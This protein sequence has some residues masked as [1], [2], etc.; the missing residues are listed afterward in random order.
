LA[1]FGRQLNALGADEGT[2]PSCCPGWDVRAMASHVLGMT[3]M[4]SSYP[5]MARQ[6]LSAAKAIKGGG[7]YLDALTAR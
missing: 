2:R 3:Q 7:G 6:H 1:R 5:R 4:F